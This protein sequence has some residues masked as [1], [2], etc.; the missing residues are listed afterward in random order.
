[1]NDLQ[2]LK[3]LKE[4]RAEVTGR[5]PED[6]RGARDLLLA[7][8]RGGG[9]RRRAAWTHDMRPR[10][11]PRPALIAGTAVAASAAITA[12]LLAGSPGHPAPAP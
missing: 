3:E 10:I 7:E 12:A 2:E 4:M 6:L 11:W 5:R 8:V 1:M 9:R